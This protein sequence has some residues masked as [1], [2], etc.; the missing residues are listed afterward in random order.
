[1][2]QAARPLAA[3]LRIGASI[4]FINGGPARSRCNFAGQRKFF[5]L[6]SR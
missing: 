3:I 4:D 6:I 1:M 2:L 5:K